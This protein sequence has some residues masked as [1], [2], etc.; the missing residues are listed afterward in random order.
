MMMTCSL[1][2][3]AN[4][5]KH[6]KTLLGKEKLCEKSKDELKKDLANQN[7]VNIYGTKVS[8]KGLTKNEKAIGKKFN[9]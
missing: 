1:F 3:A 6:A 8:S 4:Y 9:L 5:S 7:K 2:Y